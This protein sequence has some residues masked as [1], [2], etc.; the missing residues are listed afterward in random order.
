MATGAL[1]VATPAANRSGV[2]QPGENGLLYTTPEQLVTALLSG[3]GIDVRVDSQHEPGRN[4]H[5][6]SGD[7]E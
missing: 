3:L 4:E 5:L 6:W 2:I 1:V 7:M